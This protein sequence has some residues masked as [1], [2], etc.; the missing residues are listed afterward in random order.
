MQEDLFHQAL[1]EFSTDTR[2][3]RLDCPETAFPYENKLNTLKIN[4][5]QPMEKKYS[6]SRREDNYLETTYI[7]RHLKSNA[8]VNSDEK[9]S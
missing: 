5:Y 9:K 6:V 1:K 7:N 8:K 4:F 2:I 3:N